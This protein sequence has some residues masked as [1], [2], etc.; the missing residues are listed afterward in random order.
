LGIGPLASVPSQ[1]AVRKS[2]NPQS[3]IVNFLSVYPTWERQGRASS[4]D[5]FEQSR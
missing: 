4:P 2:G 1:I 3:K 5:P